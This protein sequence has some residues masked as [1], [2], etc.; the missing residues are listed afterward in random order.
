VTPSAVRT[1]QN[2]SLTLLAFYFTKPVRHVRCYSNNGQILQ[3]SEMTRCANK[4][5]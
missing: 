2:G 3:R 1:R 4:Q 5:H